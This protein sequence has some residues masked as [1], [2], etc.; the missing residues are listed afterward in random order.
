LEKADTKAM[1]QRLK[2]IITTMEETGSKL[3][4]KPKPN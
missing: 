3:N 4:Q 2:L 1:K